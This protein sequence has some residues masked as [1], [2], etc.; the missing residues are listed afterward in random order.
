MYEDIGRVLDGPIRGRVLGVSGIEKFRPL[1][2][3]SADMLD[4]TY[5]DV[6][7]LDLP[8]SAKSF[9]AVISDQVLEHLADPR[10]CSAGGVSSPSAGWARRTHHVF[11]QSD[12]SPPSGL[13]PILC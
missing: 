10:R 8:F 1:I 4:T 2:H 13:L 9:D 7:L 6:D 3:P 5:P 11:P 12:T